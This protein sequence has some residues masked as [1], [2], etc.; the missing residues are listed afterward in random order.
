MCLS[1]EWAGRCSE[2]TLGRSLAGTANSS[3]TGR[4]GVKGHAGTASTQHTQQDMK[5][6]MR[7]SA[8]SQALHWF[9]VPFLPPAHP[10][11]LS[12]FPSSLDSAV[13]EE[14]AI[15]WRVVT[16]PAMTQYT[17]GI[18]TA[19]RAL[20][21]LYK[22]EWKWMKSTIMLEILRWWKQDIP[23]PPVTTTYANAD[24]QSNNHPS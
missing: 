23:Q 15:N 5:G 1:W 16:T 12:G 4:S 18:E 19:H 22:V 10:P 11:P 17:F 6:G 9:F 8:Q 2:R 7:R 20:R 3:A 14:R 13:P 24:L 21:L